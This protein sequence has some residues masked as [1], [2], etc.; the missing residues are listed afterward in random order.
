[1]WFHPFFSHRMFGC[2]E[3]NLCMSFGQ[4]P[5]GEWPKG[6]P[7]SL[8]SCPHLW[9][10]I[11]VL[12]SR[13]PFPSRF[14]V[15]C[16][17]IPYVVLKE[18]FLQPSQLHDMSQGVF[19]GMGWRWGLKLHKKTFL[20]IRLKSAFNVSTP[21]YLCLLSLFLNVADTGTPPRLSTRPSSLAAD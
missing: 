10:Y 5:L 7:L 16:L 15:L 2:A 1:M 21:H 6:G 9:I 8:W 12:R 18:A 11:P 14:A 19:L 17:N 3:N 13:L 4:Q 20:G